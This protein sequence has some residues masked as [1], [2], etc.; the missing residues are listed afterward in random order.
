MS[1]TI[2]NASTAVANFSQTSFSQ[3]NEFLFGNYLAPNAEK[4]LI[5]ES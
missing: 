4:L 5:A 3:P 1:S 2:M